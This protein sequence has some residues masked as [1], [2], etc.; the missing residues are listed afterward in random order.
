MY[1]VYNSYTNNNIAKVLYTEWTAQ[2]MWL[3]S[4]VDTSTVIA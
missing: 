3:V 4:Y 2:L 1:F